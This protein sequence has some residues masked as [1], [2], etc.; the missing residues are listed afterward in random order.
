MTH[1]IYQALEFVLFPSRKEFASLFSFS[2]RLT[3]ILKRKKIQFLAVS[4][5]LCIPMREFLVHKKVV[6]VLQFLNTLSSDAWGNIETNKK[7][8]AALRAMNWR[9]TLI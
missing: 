2:I 5:V 1:R 6:F 3:I 8:V 4:R 9:I 7:R